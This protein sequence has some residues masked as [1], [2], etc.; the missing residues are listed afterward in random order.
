MSAL[1]RKKSLH[2]RLPAQ[3]DS[4]AAPT[5]AAACRCWRLK[6]SSD[7]TALR[8]EDRLRRNWCIGQMQEFGGEA[9]FTAV[10]AH[11]PAVALAG[12]DDD[13]HGVDSLVSCPLDIRYGAVLRLAGRAALVR[14]WIT[15]GDGGL[16]GAFVAPRLALMR[17]LLGVAR[18]PVV[19]GPA[20][21]RPISDI[22]LKKRVRM[23][24]RIQITQI[25]IVIFQ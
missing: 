9:I 20:R 10:L 23:R 6:E 17:V 3:L 13:V 22:G 21:R 2:H 18:V 15:A 25:N 12:R 16:P 1:G 7:A 8:A 14:C 19:L 5:P 4:S 11:G 24:V